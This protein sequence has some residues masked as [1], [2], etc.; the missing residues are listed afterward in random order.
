MRASAILIP[1]AT[2]TKN[3][4]PGRYTRPTNK[5]QATREQRDV[6]QVTTDKLL[7]L[8]EAGTVPWHKEWTSVEGD[9][10]RSLSTGKLYG[11]S[12]VLILWVTA[13]TNGYGSPWWGTYRQ[14]SE[15][16]GQVRKGQKGVEIV[17]TISGVKEVTD[18]D[19]QAKTQAWRT[20]RFFHVFNAEQCDW[21]EGSRAPKT[22]AKPE[23]PARI[24]AAEALVAQ[25]LATGPSLGHGGNAAYYNPPQ[26]HVQ[27]PPLAQFESAEGYLSTLYHELTHSTGHTSREA[28][29]G[30]AEGTFGRFGDAVYSEEELVAEIGAAILCAHAGIEQ[31]TLDNSAAYIAHW[32][33]ALG[34][35]KRLIF[36]AATAAQKAVDRILGTS[37]TDKGEES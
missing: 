13:L 33:K 20:L 37:E 4:R 31:T 10:P 1:M 15:R 7:A 18:E 21:P 14:I 34:E 8:L 2:A 28:R 9:M 24:E 26:D 30:I 29:Q 23:G 19:G 32:L 35:D 11:G 22:A 3:K 17:R 25:Y 16:G 27:M 36:K 5:A 6:A 12:N